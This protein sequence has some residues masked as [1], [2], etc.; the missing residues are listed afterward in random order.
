[1]GSNPTDDLLMTMWQFESQLSEE[2]RKLMEA[3]FLKDLYRTLGILDKCADSTIDRLI[4]FTPLGRALS[5]QGAL[6][7]E[8][9]R[10]SKSGSTLTCKVAF[11]FQSLRLIA[12]SLS[13]S[14]IPNTKSGQQTSTPADM[15]INKPGMSFVP[16]PGLSY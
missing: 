10:H 7:N 16:P 14:V 3:Q 12:L 9:E 5:M 11:T 2:Q 4:R 15:D 8:D 13:F 1:M 6:G